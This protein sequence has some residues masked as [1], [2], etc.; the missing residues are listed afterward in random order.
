MVMAYFFF[1]KW[2]SLENTVLN[3]IPK[4][5]VLVVTSNQIQGNSALQN[6]P[7]LSQSP[8]TL[9]LLKKAIPSDSLVTQFLS[10]KEISYSLTL[11]SQ[12]NLHFIAYIPLNLS[13][14]DQFLKKLSALSTQTQGIRSL[15]HSYQKHEITEVFDDKA[16]SIFTYLTDI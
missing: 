16:N 6:I 1:R 15:N 12:N 13:K 14:D 11:E 8:K 3:F 7:F 2:S 9:L 5:T 10:K 4:E